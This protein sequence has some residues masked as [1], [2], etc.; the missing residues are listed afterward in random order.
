MKHFLHKFIHFVCM[1]CDKATFMIEK[2]LHS[3]L[4]LKEKL[5]LK[6]HLHICKIC[7]NYSK[8]AETI[9]HWLQIMLHGKIPHIAMRSEE[10][11]QFKEQ[12]K[13]RLH[14]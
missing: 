1:P 13:Q 4:S 3:K 14:S 8:K 9:H 11:Q 6:A 12:L 2:Q 5:Q 10:I 7:L